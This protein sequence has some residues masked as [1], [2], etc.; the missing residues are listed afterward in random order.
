MESPNLLNGS[1]EINEWHEN[2]DANWYINLMNFLLNLNCSWNIVSL[3]V[4]SEKAL[5]LPENLRRI[6]R[7][8]FLNWKHLKCWFLFFPLLAV[9]SVSRPVAALGGLFPI[10]QVQLCDS[11]GASLPPS[12]GRCDEPIW[13]GSPLIEVYLGSRV[14]ISLPS[15]SMAE[16]KEKILGD[17]N[18][19]DSH[20]NPTNSVVE[21][22]EDENANIA[23][24]DRISY[25]PISLILH[26]LLYV[27]TV[28]VVRMSVLSKCWKLMWYLVPKLQFNSNV[29][30][31]SQEA[32]NT[33]LEECLLRRE[34]CMRHITQLVVTK[35]KLH[36]VYSDDQAALLDRFLCSPL[37]RDNIMELK[38]S[39]ITRGTTV[40]Y[41]LPDA[42]LN[43]RSLTVLKLENVLLLEE[44]SKFSVNLPC[45]KYLYML[46]VDYLDDHVLTNLLLGCPSLEKFELKC[47][48]LSNPRISSSSLK[49]LEITGYARENLQ[50]EAINLESLALIV[51][52]G[53]IINLSDCRLI[54]NLSID[55]NSNID[56]QLLED[57]ISKLPLLEDL[58]LSRCQLLKQVKISSERLRSFAFDKQGNDNEVKATM[59]TPNLVSFSYK[60]DIDFG[61]TMISPNVQLNG[62]IVINGSYRCICMLNFL[63]SLNCSWNILS[64]HVV[65][66]KV[67]F[68]PE[69]VRICPPPLAKLKHLKVKTTERWEYKSELRDSL[70]WASPNLETLLIEEGTEG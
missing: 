40:G 4:L 46:Y 6:C 63:L 62:S 17:K 55:L 24:V 50:V 56:D 65:S 33:F 22:N 2:Y 43:G 30:F 3:H 20:S 52:W 31:Q 16:K 25:L 18:E 21:R 60:G 69:E 5:M 26:I 38:L 47:F 59:G 9:D 7:S 67:L 48:Y 32:F 19:E 15:F 12:R 53:G 29:G 49:S 10:T 39:M 13:T 70:H 36:I 14:H 45:L 66:G 23:A 34:I 51:L 61:I 28:D 37:L 54:R 42:I 8:P 64:L 11:L 68:F 35:F 41:S 44:D 58:S 1:F 57:M 27:P